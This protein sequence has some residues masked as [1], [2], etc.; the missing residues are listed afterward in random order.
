LRHVAPPFVI[1]AQAGIQ[2]MRFE[3]P[4]G[5]PQGERSE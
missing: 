5:G 3:R 4:K 2:G 1:P